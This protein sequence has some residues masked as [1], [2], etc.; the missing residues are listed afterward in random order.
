MYKVFP[1]AAIT[2]N[3]KRYVN[4]TEIHD[5]E[6]SHS[7]PPVLFPLLPFLAFVNQHK[8]LVTSDCYN[9]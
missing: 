9:Y 1:I 8:V 3:T 6:T 2:E 5:G 7:L 4:T